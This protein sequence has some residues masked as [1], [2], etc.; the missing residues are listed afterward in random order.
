L[1]E[2]SENSRSWTSQSA[3]E[4]TS[5]LQHTVSVGAK[6]ISITVEKIDSNSFRVAAKME[7]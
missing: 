6:P 1:L 7:N 4:G 5:T 3:F 2:A